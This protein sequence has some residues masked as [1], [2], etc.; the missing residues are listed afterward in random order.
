MLLKG[1]FGKVQGLIRFLGLNRVHKEQHCA[2]RVKD[3]LL[4]EA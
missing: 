3:E 1:G 4:Q 2:V